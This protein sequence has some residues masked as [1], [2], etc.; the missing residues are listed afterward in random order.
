MAEFNL[1]LFVHIQIL[2]ILQ[3]EELIIVSFAVLLK[4]F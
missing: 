4:P 3:M 1:R 2:L